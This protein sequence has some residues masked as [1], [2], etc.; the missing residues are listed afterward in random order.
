MIFDTDNISFSVAMVGSSKFCSYVDKLFIVV[1]LRYFVRAYV[2]KH[3]LKVFKFASQLN[4]SEGQV[5]CGYMMCMLPS[6]FLLNFTVPSLCYSH[7]E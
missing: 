4:Y 6:C 7:L 5:R 2:C 1:L 3:M